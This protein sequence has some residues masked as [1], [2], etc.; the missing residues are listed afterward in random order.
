MTYF[1]IVELFEMD[2]TLQVV[3][4][5]FW[6]SS[7]SRWFWDE[8]SISSPVEMEVRSESLKVGESSWD[9]WEDG[10]TDGWN[11]VIELWWESLSVKWTLDGSSGVGVL[12][13]GM[14][15]FDWFERGTTSSCVV[16][17]GKADE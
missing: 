9:V 16:M 3:T 12:G 13:H 14:D 1:D 11:D 5:G 6:S 15:G 2:G 7:F 10:D 17:V 4:A 8:L